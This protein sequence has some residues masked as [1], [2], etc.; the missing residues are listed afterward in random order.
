MIIGKNSP[1]TSKWLSRS[2][3]VAVLSSIGW[4]HG[5]A[6]S[7]SWQSPSLVEFNA[8]ASAQNANP[9]S[10]TPDQLRSYAQSLLQIEPLRQQYYETIK[11]DLQ[12]TAPGQPVPAITCSDRNSFNDLPPN[13]RG[14]A[15]EYCKKSIEIV[16]ANNLTI[17]D[18]NQITESLS[19]NQ[20]L[21]NMITQQLLQLQLQN[22][23]LFQ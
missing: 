1:S 3:L 9:P 11:Q 16:E 18:F 20:N 10:L 23:N 2:I 7:I 22:N 17:Q 13:I 21:M 14:T 15:V 12:Q 6:P 5:L 8:A 19:T 4:L